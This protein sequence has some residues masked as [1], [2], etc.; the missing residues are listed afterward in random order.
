MGRCLASVLRDGEIL[1][2]DPTLIDTEPS[3][4][5]PDWICAWEE[6]SGQPLDQ[7]LDSA[8]AEGRDM[9]AQARDSTGYVELATR[10][11][12]LDPRTRGSGLSTAV[13][14]L[15]L[16]WMHAEDPLRGVVLAANL[17][18]SDTDTIASM[19][20]ALLGAI[21]TDA[22]PTPPADADLIAAGLRFGQDVLVKHR[23]PW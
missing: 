15:A 20:G 4:L 12:A 9:L 18:E 19:A 2:P 17:L 1:R 3:D 13:L 8:L 6:Q 16:A 10:L 22:P 7:A 21:H 23:V 14:A 11:G 5:P